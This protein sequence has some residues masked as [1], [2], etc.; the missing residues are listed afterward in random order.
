MSRLISVFVWLSFRATLVIVVLGLFTSCSRDPAADPASPGSTPSGDAVGDPLAR[1]G[2]QPGASVL[3]VLPEFSLTDQSGTTF[4]LSELRGKVWIANFIF[5]R[6]RSTCPEQSVQMGNVQKLLKKQPAWEGIRLVSLSVDPEYDTP[7][8]L[9]EYAKTYFADQD[10]WKFLTGSREEIWTL[11]KQ[12]FRLPVADDKG[13]KDM[14]IFHDTKFVLIDRM[15]RIRGYYDGLSAEGQQQLLQA[16]HFV[17]PEMEPPDYAKAAFADDTGEIVHLAQPPEIVTTAWLEERA[18]SQK[19]SVD[20]FDV[21]YDFQFTDRLS[22]SGITFQPQVVDDQ[23]WLINVTHYDHGAAISIADVDGDGREDIYF[24]SQVGRNEL[25]RNLGEGKFEDITEEAGIALS[26]RV[27][28]GAS[29]ADTDNDGDADLYVTSVR[30]GNVLFVNDG[31]GKFT[32]ATEQSGLGHVGHCSAAVFFDY[33]RDGLLDLFLTNIGKYTTDEAMSMRIDSFTSLPQGDYKF[34]VGVRDAFA[35]HLKPGY[36]EASILFR[37]E[38]NNRFADVSEETGLVDTGWTGDA[39]PL[40]L[41]GDGW[42]DLYVLSMQG[43]DEYYENVDGKRFLKKSREVFPK[44][45][46]GAMGVKW[47]DYDNDGAMDLYVT[48]MH[49]DM[50]ED[51]GPEREKLKSRMQWTESFLRSDGN[52]IFGNAFYKNDGQGNFQEISDQI[53]AETYWPWGISVADLNADAYEDVFAAAGMCF[54]YRY[55]VNSVLLNNQGEKFLDSEFLL[56]VEPRPDGQLIKP[57]FELDASGQDKDHLL[58]KGRQGR[59]VIWSAVGSRSSVIFDIDDDGD[60]DIVT[61]G[62]NSPPMVLVSN[63]TD[64]KVNVRFLKVKLVGAKSNHDGL[65]AV[66]KVQAGT[67]TYTKVNDGK[68]GYLSQS[69]CPLYFGLGEADTV[70]QIEVTW[71]SGEQTTLAGPIE[72]NSLVEVKE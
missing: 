61:N 31:S 5:T 57:W 6:C 7:E 50:S 27:G 35:G 11:S 45:P 14:P 51:V 34:F 68:S 58:C 47:F 37:N 24:V 70:D 30:G 46:W 60:L 19:A 10:H 15:G 53:G 8:V 12:G 71:P 72:T 21:F 48:D 44:T 65:G 63:L 23:R 54:P 42:L 25:W 33:D 38:G 17:L 52:S 26:D 13:N 2:K 64:R 29:F 3:G 28:V 56:G 41:N 20:Q 43:H 36:D 69:V 40:D 1:A 62:V 55:G 67:K 16:L 32:D 59:V 18:E 39:T 22:E 4:G 66:V 9:Q 49:S